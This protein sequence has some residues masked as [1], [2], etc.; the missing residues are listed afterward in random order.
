M[1]K[2][3]HSLNTDFFYK[4]PKSR[5]HIIALA[6]LFVIPLILFFE[7]TLGGKELQ[8]HDITQFKAAVESV[9]Q[10]RDTYGEEPLWASNIYGGMPSFVISLI[11]EV[12]HLDKVSGWFRSIYPA[13]QFWVLFSGM[14]F[15][16]ILM[17]FR[18]LTALLG[19]LMYGLTTYFPVII[20]AGHTSKFFALA[21][22][23]WLI[24]GYWILSRHPKKI[25]GLLL[26]TVA[27]AME[28]RA[29]HPQI[30][31]YFFY[32]IGLFWLYDTWNAYKSKEL[33]SWSVVTAFLV[34]GTIIGA[35]G[36]AERILA[37]QEYAS[38]SM[39]GGSALKGTETL[40]P[41]YAFGWSQ[42]IGETLTLL[43]P[44]LFGG[45]SPDYWG[46]KTFTS[47]PHYLGVLTLPFLLISLFKVRKKEM[48]VFLAAG[49]L[50]IFFAWGSNFGLL[51]NFAFN[52]VPF[53]SKFRAPETWLVLTAFSF[54]IVSVYGL[55]WLLD[56][57]GEKT[58]EL[59]A[60]YKPLGVALVVISGLFLYVNSTN[61][62]KEGEVDR[63][64]YQIAQQNQ[65]NP[66]NPQVVAQAR[67][68]VNTRLVPAREEKAN[69]DMLRLFLFTSI[70]IAL[71]YLLVK[72]RVSVTIGSLAL[73]LIGAIDLIGVGQRY[74]PE[75][76]FVAANIS[77]DRYIESQKRD[78]D[79]YIQ[80]NI[81][82]DDNSY[83][84]RVFPLLDGPFSTAVPAY[85]YPTLGGYT[86]AKLSIIQE[87]FIANPN[88]LYSGQFGIN[89]DLLA[90]LN[91]KYITYSSGLS[92]PGLSPVF[93]DRSGVVY[94]LNNVLPKAFFVDS[95][96]TVETASEAFEYLNPGKIDF[97]EV[98][99]I[100]NF[101]ATTSYDSTSSVEII[102][103]TGAEITLK[104]SRT[105]PGFLV[106]SEIYYP[107]GWVALLDGEE[108]TIHKT[109]Y[110]IR[111]FQ[112]PAGEHTLE[113]D[114]KPES[115]ALGVKLSWF[116]L[117]SQ[118]LL[119]LT[120]GFIFYRDRTKRE[121]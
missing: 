101:D 93:N 119:A 69:S 61:F 5:Q 40:D 8:R 37:L 91:T 66:Q 80:E 11:K 115:Y 19:S 42:G 20:I 102:N 116:S 6:I 22:I 87:A 27:L 45:A 112:I 30:T 105:K 88:P 64:A 121:S 10:Y 99:V 39:R 24:S 56:Y 13:F 92:I 107:A 41:S 89:L 82:S 86:A 47:G 32:L 90:M 18:S 52:Y 35:M 21:L 78:L 71:I 60:L 7:T 75:T 110:L 83:P 111:G 26:F 15:L 46:P 34:I 50:G 84:Y 76:S 72:K 100:E 95:T 3:P 4:L 113:L 79:T 33:K 98:A 67:N 48:F 14:Y 1:S 97:S 58:S 118:I 77:P 51:N 59:K 17:G 12:P 54:S 94:Q 36:H 53:F 70:S 44:N 29:G 85:F 49:I 108:I 68:Y 16:L 62:I 106:L 23:P 96:I 117:I 81:Y 65:V 9:E 63:I 2:S 43:L 25:Y 120:A 38:F 114:F 103:Y 104:T 109:N 57:I 55:E 73:L 74:M 31:Y 28:I